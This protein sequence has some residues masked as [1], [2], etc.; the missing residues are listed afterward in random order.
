MSG[1]RD[2]QPPCRLPDS[3]LRAGH[4]SQETRE[5]ESLLRPD[6]DG[7]TVASERPGTDASG[8]CPLL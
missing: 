8:G 6:A 7:A 4:N 5:V 1:L 2:I 3:G